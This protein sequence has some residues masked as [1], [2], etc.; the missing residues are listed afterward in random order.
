LCHNAKPQAILHS[1]D[2]INRVQ[3]TTGHNVAP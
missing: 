1:I 3:L 2:S